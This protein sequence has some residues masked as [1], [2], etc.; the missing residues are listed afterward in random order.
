MIMKNEEQVLTA[1]YEILPYKSFNALLQAMD[2]SKMFLQHKNKDNYENN[3]L[4]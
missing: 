2:T 1:R 4:L 3:N